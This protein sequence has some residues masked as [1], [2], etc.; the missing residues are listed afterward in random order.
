MTPNARKFWLGLAVLVS[1]IALG[2][3]LKG[4]DLVPTLS[5]R[6]PDLTPGAYRPGTVVGARGS[7]EIV[8]VYVGSSRCVWSNLPETSQTVRD[9]KRMVASRAREAGMGF[10]ALG[11]AVDPDAIAGWAHLEQFGL[12]DE[13]IVGKGWR[14]TGSRRYIYGPLSGSAATPQ[15]LLTIRSTSGMKNDERV[16]LRKIGSTGIAG[17]V[18]DGA[19]LP[20]LAGS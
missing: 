2:S 7:G 15:L 1:G 4:I 17:W 6:W 18:A 11:I 3:A 12:F 5:I 16:L 8:F 9:A 13:A 14:N 20:P 19:P 10:A